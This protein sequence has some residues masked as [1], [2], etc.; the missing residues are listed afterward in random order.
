MLP[1]I[2]WMIGMCFMAGSY[3]DSGLNAQWKCIVHKSTR[4]S[5]RQSVK[6]QSS[7][8]S[9]YPHNRD[10]VT[11]RVKQAPDRTEL[12]SASNS[13]NW[14]VYQEIGTSQL[15]DIIKHSDS[16]YFSQGS[17]CRSWKATHQKAFHW[18]FLLMFICYFKD[19][20]K[21]EKSPSS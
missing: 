10:L 14:G 17:T 21:L 13:Q 3:K 4:K 11:V 19:A 16:S 8:K 1:S 9:V 15:S 6:K 2:S 7:P 18:N 20:F 5:G 12:L